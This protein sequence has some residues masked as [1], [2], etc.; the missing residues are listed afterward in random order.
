M[1]KG[2]EDF[3]GAQSIAGLPQHQ[4]AL[5]RRGQGG[6]LFADALGAAQAAPYQKGHVRPYGQADAL[7]LLRG[8]AQLPQA[9]QTDQRRRRVRAAAAHAR[10]GGDRL[11]QPHPRAVFDP[12]GLLQRP[13]GPDRQI[14]FVKRNGRGAGLS[15]P[16]FGVKALPRVLQREPVAFLQ[17]EGVGQP[18]GLHQ[19]IHLMIAV[20]P[21]AQ[22]IQ[23]PVDFRPRFETKHCIVPLFC[24][25]VHSQ[26]F[27]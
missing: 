2:R 19:H 18:N 20:G 3:A 11:A 8:E 24:D 16:R 22:N 12:R 6:Q 15:V 9:V 17:P 5:G 25:I 7:Q 21:P 13:G 4:P 1:V 10:P 27:P 26:G 23:R 14:V